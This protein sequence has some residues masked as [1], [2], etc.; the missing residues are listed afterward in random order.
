MNQPVE[1]DDIRRYCLN[2]ELDRPSIHIY[3][4]VALILVVIAISTVFSVVLHHLAGFNL[5]FTFD[6]C[7]CT[8]V[9]CHAKA[10]MVFFIHCYQHYAPEDMRRQCSCMPSCSEY[11]LLALDKYLWPK[12]L[13]KIWRRLAYT[14]SAP[15]YHI[16]YP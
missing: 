14:C 9:L 7:V 4:V 6:I 10:I 2:R 12:A 15:G 8:I 13:W 16:D 1:V 3:K 11:A 5:W